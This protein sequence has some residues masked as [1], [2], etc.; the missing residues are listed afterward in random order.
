MAQCCAI[1][2]EGGAL[3]V[4]GFAAICKALGHPARVRIVQFLKGLDS[5]YCG[6][7][8]DLL[9][10]AQST[11]SQHLKCLKDAGLIVGRVEGSCTC[12]CLN[13]EIFEKF[14]RL[15]DRL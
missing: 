11:V 12:Y 2:Q 6:Q 15:A 4:E 10:L 9:P 1:D 13:R 5:C 8:V 7:I 3:D 14:L